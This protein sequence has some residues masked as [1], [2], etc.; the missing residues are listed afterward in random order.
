MDGRGVYY[1]QKANRVDKVSGQRDLGSLCA[2]RSLDL[3][4]ALSS[5][6]GQVS[7]RIETGDEGKG[8]EVVTKGGKEEL[9]RMAQ[10]LNLYE[11]GMIKVK[12]IF[13]N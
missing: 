7:V 8:V 11:K 2:S 10:V 6:V 5:P 12:G 13:E 3:D 9:E 4:G 1:W